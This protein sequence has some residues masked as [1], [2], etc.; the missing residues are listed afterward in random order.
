MK[1]KIDQERKKI[2]AIDSQLRALLNERAQIAQKIGH[3]KGSGTIYRPEREAQ[4]LRR[5]LE[6]NEG[7]LNDRMVFRIQREIMSACLSLEKPLAVGYKKGDFQSLLGIREQFGSFALPYEFSHLS[8]GMEEL[9]LGD[10]DHLFLSERFLVEMLKEKVPFFVQ[11]EW[12]SE[13][14]GEIFYV[15]GKESI[16]PSGLDK[17]LCISESKLNLAS[18]E[19]QLLEKRHL[20]GEIFLFSFSGHRNDESLRIRLKEYQDISV[21]GSYPYFQ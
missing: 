6:E 19:S 3:L 8:K 13:I 1:E 10:R 2:D 4:V 7:P 14:S 16:P 17:T 5:A 9:S 15:I 12:R 20:S 11:G 18:L 21:L